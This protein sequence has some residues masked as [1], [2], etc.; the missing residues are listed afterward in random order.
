MVR[1]LVCWNIRCPSLHVVWAI[2]ITFLGARYL[3][4]GRGEQRDNIMQSE[5]Q[6][7]KEA[8]LMTPNLACI[9]LSS[10]VRITAK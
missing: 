3:D 2:T 10:D 8:L 1:W 5:T 4:S 7:N 6:M 9:L